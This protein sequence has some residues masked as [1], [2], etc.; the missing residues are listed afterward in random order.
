MRFLLLYLLITSCANYQVGNCYY[1]GFG[2]YTFKILEKADNGW[3]K[4]EQDNGKISIGKPA[5]Y[6]TKKISC[7]EFKKRRYK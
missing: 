2:A 6:D 1:T 7:E 4:M 5:A 3:Y